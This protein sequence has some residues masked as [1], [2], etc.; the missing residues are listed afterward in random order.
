MFSLA[1]NLSKNDVEFLPID[2]RNNQ[3]KSTWKQREVFDQQN[4]TENQRRI[5]VNSMWC[6]RWVDLANNILSCLSK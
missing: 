3:N 5:D 1:Y 2:Q 4:Y 6:T